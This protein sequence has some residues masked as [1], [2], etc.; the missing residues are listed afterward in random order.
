MDFTYILE[1]YHQ[2][3]DAFWLTLRI[4][5]FGIFLSFLLG[6]FCAGFRAVP[7]LGL[8][9]RAY[10]ELSRNTPLLIQIIFLYYALPK[11]GISLSAEVCG[12][13][14]L[15]FLGGGYMCEAFG[16]GLS[17]VEKIQRESAL[18]LGLSNTQA[19]FYVIL[20]QALSV[21]VPAFLANVVFLLKETS[22]FSAVAL[23]DLMFVAKDLIGLYYKTDEAL[24]LL[25]ISYLILLLPISILAA[26][27]ERRLRYAQF[28][29]N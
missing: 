14:G 19:F 20:P 29:H 22:V 10:I 6:L 26:F 21:S 8:L 2:F 1:N 17:S 25:C 15:A 4:G 5:A 3:I 12:I 9:I 13:L 16:S 27:A 7:V 11:V 28:G 23:A 18:S 24:T